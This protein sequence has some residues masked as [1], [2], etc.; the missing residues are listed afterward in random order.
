MLSRSFHTESHIYPIR[1]N[2]NRSAGNGFGAETVERA[3]FRYAFQ[4][5]VRL[6]YRIHLM[7][8]TQFPL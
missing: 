4:L 7:K 3:A 8:M 6:Y 1:M 2:A 5:G